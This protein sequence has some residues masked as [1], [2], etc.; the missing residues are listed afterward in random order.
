MKIFVFFIWG[1]K[2]MLFECSLCLWSHPLN[3]ANSS[4][5]SLTKYTMILKIRT[6]KLLTLKVRSKFG[7][8]RQK[9]RVSVDKTKVV[10]KQQSSYIYMAYTLLW[11]SFLLLKSLFQY[12]PPTTFLLFSCRVQTARRRVKRRTYVLLQYRNRSKLYT[13]KN[14]TMQNGP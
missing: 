3:Q 4:K 8:T 6:K 12:L 9:Q 13:S 10:P 1:E 5:K 14:Q 7:Q 2:L 11:T